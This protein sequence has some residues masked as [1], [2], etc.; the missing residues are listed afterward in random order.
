MSKKKRC[1]YCKS[2]YVPYARQAKRQKTCGE[3]ECRRKHKRVLDRAWRAADPGWSTARRGKIRDWARAKGYWRQWRRENPEYRARE[4]RRMRLKR[5]KIV[6]KQD[7]LNRDPVGYL[8]G[9]RDLKAL[10]V[11]KQD[12]LGLRFDEVLDY[13]I[14]RERV[15][16]QEGGDEQGCGAV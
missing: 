1:L 6:A 8:N 7:L 13:L 12:L 15:A 16:K 4:E 5:A 14:Q 9:V 2:W 3:A 10:G 11:A